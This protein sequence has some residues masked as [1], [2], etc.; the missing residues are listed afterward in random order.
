[1]RKYATDRERKGSKMDASRCEYV[2]EFIGVY[3]AVYEPM[4]EYRRPLKRF[5]MSQYPNNISRCVHRGR[6]LEYHG[7]VFRLLL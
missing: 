4:A 7:V 5:E 2:S 1:M 6:P 3:S